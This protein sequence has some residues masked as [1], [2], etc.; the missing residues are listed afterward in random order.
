MAYVHIDFI[1]IKYIEVSITS[2]KIFTS[3]RG[4]QNEKGYLKSSKFTF[5][6]EYSSPRLLNIDKV[7]DLF[8]SDEETYYGD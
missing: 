8:P 7:T 5:W 2:Y 1:L 4:F 6:G 3:N